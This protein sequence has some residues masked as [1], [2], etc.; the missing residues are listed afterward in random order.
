MS[1]LK[2]IIKSAENNNVLLFTVVHQVD[3][4]WSLLI[5]FERRK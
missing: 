2:R 1:E 3:I 5:S 4:F